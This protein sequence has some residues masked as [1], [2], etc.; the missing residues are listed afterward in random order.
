MLAE[1]LSTTG[2]GSVMAGVKTKNSFWG[3]GSGR[4]Q[5]LKRR[6]VAQERV[7][8]TAAPPHSEKV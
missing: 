4:A 1:N 5:A 3:S 8:S 6:R 7:G 2:S